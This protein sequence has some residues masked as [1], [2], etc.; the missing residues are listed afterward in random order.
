[1]PIGRRPLALVAPNQVL[2]PRQAARLSVTGEPMA[3]I[4]LRCYTR[5]SVTYSTV[6]YVTLSTTGAAAFELRP[7]ANTR[8]FA[9]YGADDTTGSNS[10]VLPVHRAVA[11]TATR[12][13]PNTYVFSGTVGPA[14][15]SAVVSVWRLSAAGRVLTARARTDALGHWRAEVRF[16]PGPAGRTLRFEATTPPSSTHAAGTSNVVS[17]LLH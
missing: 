7:P 5:P 2:L 16:L 11:M 17:L 8:C 4:E 12:L 6:R 10:V 14:A 3:P 1:V 13:R 15:P 9:R